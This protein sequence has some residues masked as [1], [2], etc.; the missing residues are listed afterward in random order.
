MPERKRR[1]ERTSDSPSITQGMVKRRHHLL[2]LPQP[3][4]QGADPVRS[5]I[6][7]DPP[8]GAGPVEAHGRCPPN[9]SASKGKVK[10]ARALTSS[11]MAPLRIVSAASTISGQYWAFS[12]TMNTRP[13]SRPARSIRSQASRVGHRLLAQ[14]VLPR[15]Q[16]LQGGPLVQVMRE[17]DVHGVE[18]APGQGLLQGAEDRRPVFAA[19]LPAA[20]GSRSM[21]AVTRT[22]GASEAISSRW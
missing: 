15:P 8:A 20:S 11:P 22:R 16:A 19:T 17:Q 21:A 1:M 13:D 3:H 7:G 12:A 10:A 14:D 4:P 5:A 6:D 2:D 18:V 9:H